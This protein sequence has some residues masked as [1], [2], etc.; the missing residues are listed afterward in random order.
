MFGSHVHKH[1][2]LA[3]LFLAL[4]ACSAPSST[5]EISP[6]LALPTETVPP[7]TQ[8]PLPLAA[9][10]NGEPILLDE[11]LAE[12]NR[13]QAAQAALGNPIDEQAARRIVLD[14][15]V[16]Q[17]LLAQGAAEAGFT[18]DEAALQARL[19]AL[20]NH[21]GG[22]E[23]LRAWM[24][25]QGY[26]D[27]TLRTALKRAIAAAWMRDKII[28]SIPQTARQVHIRQI[29]L[30]NETVAQNYYRQLQAGA[31]FDELA[32][33]VDPITGGDIGWFPRNYLPS[34]EVEEA[35]FSLEVGG[36]SAIVQ[37]EAGYHILK[38]LEVQE[39]R[40]LS[41]DALLALQQRALLDWLAQ[42]RQQSVID[43]FVQ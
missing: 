22:I 16:S 9:R 12:L 25:A 30:Y 29:L 35:A 34:K 43:V 18:L 37:S 38:L 32:A 3:L 7:P 23:F 8:T 2:L 27:D 21:L 40:P 13:Y 6:T 11:F 28:S 14:D 15:L 20:A 33:R 39:E 36:I 17:V 41:P 26:T 19:A 31:D 10:V 42:R 1:G 4:S 5:P 24:Q